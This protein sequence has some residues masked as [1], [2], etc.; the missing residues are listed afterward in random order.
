[1]ASESPIVYT[2]G[3]RVSDLGSEVLLMEPNVR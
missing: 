3:V 2:E 1:M